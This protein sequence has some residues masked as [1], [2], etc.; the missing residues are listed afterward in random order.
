MPDKHPTLPKVCQLRTERQKFR[1]PAKAALT[2][3]GRG[4]LPGTFTGIILKL[5]IENLC[6]RRHIRLSRIAGE[7]RQR[8][9]ALQDA[10][11]RSRAVVSFVRSEKVECGSGRQP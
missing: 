8:T 1:T 4:R 7:K 9:G 10:S 6:R 3:R 11:R 2:A 5:L